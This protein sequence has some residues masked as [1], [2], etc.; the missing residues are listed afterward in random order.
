MQAKAIVE[1]LGREDTNADYISEKRE[2]L[3]I[4]DEGM[5]LL[6]REDIAAKFDA[7]LNH[8][9]GCIISKYTLQ[10]ISHAFTTMLAQY[11]QE[12]ILFLQDELMPPAS[13][14][15]I[16]QATEDFELYEEYFFYS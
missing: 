10:Q 15:Y 14:Y 1:W 6:V 2:I 3:I 4:Y 13:N 16:L 12:G 8:W 9:A 11:R 5:R 7:L